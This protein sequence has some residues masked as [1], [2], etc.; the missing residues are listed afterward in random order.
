MTEEVTPGVGPLDGRKPSSVVASFVLAGPLGDY[1]TTPSSLRRPRLSSSSHW[2]SVR[3]G[4]GATVEMAALLGS[5][6]TFVRA[7]P[8]LATV[9]GKSSNSL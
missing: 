9:G 2:R 5:L 8:S 3:A 7:W 1:V 6:G 4:A